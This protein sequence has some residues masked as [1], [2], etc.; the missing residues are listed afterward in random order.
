MSDNDSEF[1]KRLFDTFKVE[2]REHLQNICTGLLDLEKADQSESLSIIEIVFREVHSLK[3]AARAV[4][5][6]D[7]EKLCQAMESVFS[8]LRKATLRPTTELFDLLQQAV[9]ILNQLLVSTEPEHLS[10][11]RIVS[12]ELISML[13]SISS[14]ELSTAEKP[15]VEKIANPR[16]NKKAQDIEPDKA[17]A[18]AKPK[19]HFMP[20]TVRVS[21]E[22]LSSLLMQSEEMLS[23]KLTVH[24]QAIDLRKATADFGNWN[25]QWLKTLPYVQQVKTALNHSS[26]IGGGES[27][28][29]LTAGDTDR[30]LDFLDWNERF[31]VAIKERYEAET[32]SL[33]RN[34]RTLGGMV[35]NLLDDVKKV[36]MFPFSSLLE[37]L[38]KVVRDLA[39]SN[40]KSIE[41][42]LI[43]GE[44]EID[45]RILE[46][47][48]DPLIHLL[49]NCIDH[50]I[51]MPEERKKKNKSDIGTITVSVSPKD[52]NV[53]L[54][55]ADDGRGI[56]LEKIRSALR[57]KGGALGQ[58]VE[59][60]NDHELLLSIFSSGLSTSSMI[61]EISGRGLGLAIVREKVEKLGGSVS[62]E[63]KLDEWTRFIIILPLTVATFR[64]VLVLCD[65]RKFV[66]PTIYVERVLRL[67]PE[68]IRTVE[69]RK[70]I[71][72]NEEILAVVWLSLVLDLPV[73]KKPNTEP[74][75][76][77]MLILNVVGVRIVFVVDEVLSEQ[78]VLFKSLGPQ[79]TRVINVSGATVLGNGRVVPILNVPDLLKSAVKKS[80]DVLRTVAATSEEH[81]DSI[82][83]V[84]IAEDSITTRTLLK[85]IL[86][87]SGYLVDAAV[88]GMDAFSRLKNS[89]FDILVS[90]VDMPRLNG[91]ELTARIRREP[92]LE[93]L[94]VVLVTALASREDRE[95]GVD[96][97][98][99]AYIVKS[100]FDQ[101]DLLD[102]LG[103]LA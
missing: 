66:I 83:R 12:R 57:R 60:L 76:L 71:S 79:L 3:G 22:K 93:N 86:E 77:Q 23:A 6:V 8:A 47:M 84:L 5:L 91:F 46:E 18:G 9:D 36:L 74:P 39:K 62:V 37:I 31:V 35:D 7:I 51:E 11:G 98:A 49:R 70:T 45:K 103:R 24:Q 64:G 61:T 43:G 72:L 10:H 92:G 101:S 67:T 63:S 95:R 100:S 68:E 85:N 69:N 34:G 50:G 89:Q 42:S 38:P 19:L 4:N 90:D 96:V 29:G 27:S 20:D 94:P 81:D 78:E 41:L 1:L 44:I 14:Q 15:T 52:N 97:G 25:K 13:E 40:K 65:N 88:D 21:T 56:S 30:I 33:E 58:D 54:V 32:V 80:S 48:K 26:L 55:V 28:N 2:A 73:H 16:E 87:T 59:A 102:V 17:P 99:N 82:T 75:F 53:E